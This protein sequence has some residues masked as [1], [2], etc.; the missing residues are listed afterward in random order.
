MTSL[1]CTY[2]YRLLTAM[3]MVFRNDAEWDW[4]ELQPGRSIRQVETLINVDKFGRSKGNVYNFAE[5]GLLCLH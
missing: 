5:H 4:L 1:Y 3:R 2:R